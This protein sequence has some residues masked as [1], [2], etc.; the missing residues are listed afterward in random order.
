M[1]V[2]FANIT[3]RFSNFKTGVKHVKKFIYYVS[4]QVFGFLSD[5]QMTNNC[6]LFIFNKS[7]CA[8]ENMSI[9]KPFD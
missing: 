7:H 4:S 6:L 1:K 3:P 2:L 9:I 5:T 8:K